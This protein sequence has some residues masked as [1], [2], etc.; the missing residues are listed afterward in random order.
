[1]NLFN[2]LDSR[3]MKLSKKKIAQFH[4]EIDLCQFFFGVCYFQ[5]I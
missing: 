2:G 1:M 5:M 3:N 4:T